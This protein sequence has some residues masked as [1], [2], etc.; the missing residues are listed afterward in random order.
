MCCYSEY[1][2]LQNICLLNKSYP[3]KTT[4]FTSE[5]SHNLHN[6]CTQDMIVHPGVFIKCVC[7]GGGGGGGG[8]YSFP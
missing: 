1:Q 4:V 6:N 7:V 5:L 2:A 3:S 8:G